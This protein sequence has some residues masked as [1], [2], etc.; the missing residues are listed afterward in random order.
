MVHICELYTPICSIYLEINIS[1]SEII[2]LRKF[3]S[4]PFFTEILV[5]HSKFTR[6][7]YFSSFCTFVRNIQ[8]SLI[9]VN[10]P[11]LGNLYVFILKKRAKKKR[12]TPLIQFS[13]ISSGC[14]SKATV[15][16]V[17]RYSALRVQHIA[18]SFF[19]VASPMD[20][21]QSVRNEHDNILA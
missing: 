14:V 8:F 3:T 20:Y 9:L 1:V 15:R 5:F 17:H 19:R 16:V 7:E 13:P 12:V 18:S 2:F 10:Y 11:K 21:L 4:L 6:I